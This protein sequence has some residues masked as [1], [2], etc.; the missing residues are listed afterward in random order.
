MAEPSRGSQISRVGWLLAG[1]TVSLFLARA[2]DS[3]IVTF[4]GDDLHVSPLGV[5]F[6]KGK[7]LSRLKEDATVEYQAQVTLFRD[8]FVT[9]FKR[10]ELRF[11]VS[12]DIWGTGDQF[13]VS[14]VGT[15]SRKATN[16]SRDAT[17]TWCLERVAVAATGIA[18][19]RQFW[20][21]LELRTVPPNIWPVVG[22]K[23]LSV[24]IIDFWSRIPGADERQV[25]NAGPLRL[26]DLLHTQRR[27][28]G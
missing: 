25:F 24:N 28:P 5:H 20:L 22:D 19:D 4:D 8:Q 7:S 2:A 23:T 21:Q 9:P 6:L 27:G 3:L 18:P 12:Y 16:M 1:L 26:K 13:G 11:D 15:P 10:S 17:E 14:T